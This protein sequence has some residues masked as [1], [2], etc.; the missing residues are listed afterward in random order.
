MNGRNFIIWWALSLALVACVRAEDGFVEPVRSAEV[1]VQ[2]ALSLEGSAASTKADV[3]ALTEISATPS[4]RGITSLSVLPFSVNAPVGL[5]NISLG[6]LLPLPSISGVE[7]DMASAD[8]SLF[9]SGLIRNNRSHLFAGPGTA[10]PVGTASALVYAAAR[11]EPAATMQAEK[12]LNGSLRSDGLDL[13]AESLN[14]SEIRFSPDPILNGT[15]P[16][17]A[18]LIAD[19]LNAIA[20]QAYY[21]QHFYYKRG[22]VWTPSSVAVRW[23]DAIQSTLLRE[24]YGD[25]TNR[26]QLLTGAGE[27]VANMIGSLYERLQY[28]FMDGTAYKIVLDGEEYPAC[29]SEDEADVLT[30]GYMYNSLRD[31][32]RSR[33][34]ALET[35]GVISIHDGKVSFASPVL[36]KYPVSDGLPAGSAVLRW[37]GNRFAPVSEGLDGISAID[38]FCYMPPLYYFSNTAVSTSTERNLYRQYTSEKPSWDSILSLYRSSKVVSTRTQSVALDQQL[39]YACGMLVLTVKASGIQLA[40]NDGDPYTNCTPENTHFPVTGIIIGSQ[41]RQRYDFTPDPDA[42][43]EY[44]LYDNRISGI[45]L[46]TAQSK[47]LRTLALPTPENEDVYFF[48]EMRND[49]GSPFYGAEGII[50]PG[51]YFYLAGCLEKPAE[52][53]GKTRVFEKDHYTTV[54]CTVGTLENAHISIPELGD[55]QLMLGV[56]TQVNWI[57]SAGSYIVLD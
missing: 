1:P 17:A 18:Q 27:N 2:L 32:L 9:H 22:G 46:T 45:Y 47:A 10:L 29:L 51:S 37:N 34:L 5:E 54:H 42:T 20:R 30:Y 49:S 23:N 48:L 28:Q 35:S 41:Y 19:A 4:F 16:D 53:S 12:H 43:S 25:F 40:D 56:Q 13:A 3:A 33:I 39:Q 55:P 57:Q 24:W 15:L 11:R 6:S 8:G 36:Q 44:Y 31:L 14:V 52:E 50:M 21:T 7:D 38:R 26:G